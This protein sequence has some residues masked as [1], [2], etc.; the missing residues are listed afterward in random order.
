VL[1]PAVAEAA[2]K[3]EAN[4]PVLV[5]E[6]ALEPSIVLVTSVEPGSVTSLADATPRLRQDLAVRAAR[7]RSHDLY[8]QVEDERAGGA[9]LEEAAGKLKLPYRVVDAI[10][11]DLKTPKGDAI[12][13]IPN[14]AA[15]VKEAFESDVGVENSPIRATGDSWVFFDVVD[16]TPARDRSLDEVRNDVAAAWTAKETE[17]RVTALADSLFAK[18]KTGAAIT[19]VAAEIG[20]PVETAEGVKRNSSQPNLTE[21]AV[22]QAFAGPEGHVANAEGAGNAHILLKVDKVTAPAFFAEAADSKT[23]QQQLAQALRNDLISTYNRQ[24]L[25]T[26]PTTINN[27]AYRQLTG[28]LQAQ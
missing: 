16:T 14:G 19:S 18:L 23:I 17:D 27:V 26:R 11:A 12:T 28:Q 1:D 20:K 2:F 8:D 15:V 6:G 9:T 10:A 13:D 21:N 4:K 24:L 7:E 22:S 25:E 5:T 3:A